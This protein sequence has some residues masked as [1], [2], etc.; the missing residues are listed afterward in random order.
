MINPSKRAVRMEDTI[1]AALYTGTD[2]IRNGFGN[3]DCLLLDYGSGVF[4]VADAAERFPEASR[5]LLMRMAVLV[6]GE[7]GPVDNRLLENIIERV[8][9]DRNTSKNRR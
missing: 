8:W 6:S 3:G 5:T 1:G 2:K 9:A 4:A 7:K